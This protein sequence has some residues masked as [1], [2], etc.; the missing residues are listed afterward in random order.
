MSQAGPWL[1]TSNAQKA[2]AVAYLATLEPS[3]DKPYQVTIKPHS[4]KRRDAQNRLSH[5]W[6]GEVAEQG[7]EYTAEEVKNIAKLRWGVPILLAENEDFAA[8]WALATAPREETK[9]SPS[10]EEQWKII[11]PHT[12]VTSLMTVKQ[13]SRYL[14]DFQRVMGSKYQLTDPALLGLE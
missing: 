11:M 10:Y 14:G 12:P 4:E 6:Y 2:A 8:F 13:M 9:T 7:E 5:R 3:H 1:I